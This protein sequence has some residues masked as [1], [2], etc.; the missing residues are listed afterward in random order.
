MRIGKNKNQIVFKFIKTLCS[1]LTP[2]MGSSVNIA[3]HVT[4]TSTCQA[5]LQTIKINFKLSSNTKK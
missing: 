3:L 1:F 5:I 2:F 4:K